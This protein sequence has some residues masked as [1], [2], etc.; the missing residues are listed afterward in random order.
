MLPQ[1]DHRR[2]GQ[3]GHLELRRLSEYD[4]AGNHAMP[5]H[6]RQF[7]AA[8]VGF[9]ELI[10]PVLN[11]EPIVTAE[12]VEKIGQSALS[13]CAECFGLVENRRHRGCL[14]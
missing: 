12:R 3:S 11:V 14:S 9:A 8:V 5:M 6:D 1:S 13:V 10:Q 2:D 7:I 4:V